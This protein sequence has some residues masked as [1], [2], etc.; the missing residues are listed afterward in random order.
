MKLK[1]S[2]N[3]FANFSEVIS[4]YQQKQLHVHASI[5][6]RCNDDINIYTPLTFLKT[7]TLANGNSLHIYNNLQR[8]ENKDGE[9]LVQYLR[10]TPGRILFNQCVNDIFK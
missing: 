7:V 2:N 8:K 4:A 3:Y 5:W 1:G 10:T 9:F 6:V